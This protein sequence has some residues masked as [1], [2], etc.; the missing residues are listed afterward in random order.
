MTSLVAGVVQS[1][2]AVSWARRAGGSAV[3]MGEWS[4][5]DGGGRV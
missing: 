4:G 3:Y 1:T 2:N 5:A